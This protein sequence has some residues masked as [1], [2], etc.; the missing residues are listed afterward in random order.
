MLIR[1]GGH[2]LAM[3]AGTIQGY[4]A[5]AGSTVA[6]TTM[7]PRGST[8]YAEAMRDT[9]ASAMFLPRVNP[10]EDIRSRFNR[11]PCLIMCRKVQKSK[12]FRKEK[13]REAR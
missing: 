4:M 9:V 13:E 12:S 3:L 1:F 5:Q 6:Q 8:A 7:D 2:A 11:I 10:W